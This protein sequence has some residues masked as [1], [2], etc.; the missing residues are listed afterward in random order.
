MSPHLDALD[1]SLPPGPHA[2]L[3]RGLVAVHEAVARRSDLVTI[4]S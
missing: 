2:E 4:G 3:P 1:T